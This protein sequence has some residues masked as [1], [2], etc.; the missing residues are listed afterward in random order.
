MTKCE[1]FRYC[2]HDLNT[3]IASYP[4]TLLTITADQYTTA[5]SALG[6]QTAG[7]ERPFFNWNVVEVAADAPESIVIV[8]RRSG[9]FLLCWSFRHQESEDQ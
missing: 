8:Q 7:L 3:A 9:H 4:F 2:F 6:L 1:N 5:T